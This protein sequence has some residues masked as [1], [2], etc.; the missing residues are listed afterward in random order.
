MSRTS[1]E[2][3]FECFAKSLDVEIHVDQYRQTV[4][5][6]DMESSELEHGYLRLCIDPIDHV[7]IVETGISLISVFPSSEDVLQKLMTLQLMA[8]P[9]NTGKR[10]FPSVDL[11]NEH[12][13]LSYVIGTQAIYNDS[14]MVAITEACA[15]EVTV[16]RKNLREILNTPSR[17]KPNPA[18]ERAHRPDWAM[19]RR[20]N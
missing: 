16:M 11:Q 1:I 6:V 7:M 17:P 4:K 12:L 13:I 5:Y 19:K 8:S 20:L 15:R 2:Q 9:A 18:A 3:I 14:D 10:F